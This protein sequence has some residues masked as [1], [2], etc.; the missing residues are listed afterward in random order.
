[1]TAWTLALPYA[2]PPLTA[3]QRLH[4]LSQSTVRTKL[5]SDVQWLARQQHI[6][7]MARCS[8]SLHWA[9]IDRRRRDADNLVPTL[10]VACDALVRIGVVADDTPGLM[11]KY[12]PVIEPPEKPARLWLYITTDWPGEVT[13]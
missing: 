4:W 9:P 11:H 6:P 13:S 3:N 2:R 10:K 12:M 1:M 7:A 5:I 8:V